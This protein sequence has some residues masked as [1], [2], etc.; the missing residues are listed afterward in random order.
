MT[1]R[2]DTSAIHEVATLIRSSR[3]TVALTGAGSSTPSG[4]PDFRSAGS[5]LWARFLPMEVAS[6]TAFRH[7]PE[8]FFEWLR[9]LASHMLNA[10]PNDAHIALA[11]LEKAGCLHTI[12]TQNIDGLHQRAGS[13]HVLEVHG[14]LNTLSCIGCY[15]KISSQG[16]IDQYIHKGIIPRCPECNR[17]LKPD[18]VLFEEQ[19]PAKIWLQAR[20]AA[21][22]CE[23]MI[24]AG[25]SLL[26]MPVAGLPMK[27]VENGAKL[28]IINRSE[29]YID[30][31]A[32][33]LLN[34]DV[35]E[36]IPEIAAQ[37]HYA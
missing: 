32:T 18:T 8:R 28:I 16:Y 4:I 27:A 15:Q 34:G 17:I 14:T 2:V 21:E 23:V 19:L 26:V 24:V 35:A 13:Q 25:S 22:N 9:P 33:A 37:I 1:T 5:G 29:T 7:N 3:N 30:E 31:R 10:Q 6:L 36:I 11:E 20:K 12:I